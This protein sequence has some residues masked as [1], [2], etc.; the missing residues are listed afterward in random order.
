M[1]D[2]NHVFEPSRL[3]F[4]VLPGIHIGQKDASVIFSGGPRDI[5]IAGGRAVHRVFVDLQETPLTEDR[6]ADRL[7]AA[8]LSL[9]EAYYILECAKEYGLLGCAIT[10]RDG[11]VT[12]LFPVEGRAEDPAAAPEPDQQFAVSRFCYVRNRDRR[13]VIETPLCT[14]V[15]TLLDPALLDILF[16]F[17]TPTKLSQV[18]HRHPT[19][20]AQIVAFV[21]HLSRIGV[22]IQDDE[23]AAADG[24]GPGNWEFHDLLF[25]RRTRIG[26]HRYPVGA[27]TSAPAQILPA[28][29]VKQ[30]QFAAC[31]L[32]DLP[33]PDHDMRRKMA[34]RRFADV[35]R[36]R[37]SIRSYARP[38]TLGELGGFLT[39]S[40][41]ARQRPDSLRTKTTP[42]L[43]LHR[44]Y[45]TGG[46]CY[47]LE[48]YVFARECTGL[49]AG[50][51]HYDPFRHALRDIG[52][53]FGQQRIQDLQSLGFDALP[54]GG[55]Q[56]LIMISSFHQRLSMKYGSIAYALTLKHVG[57]LMQSFYLAA[58]ALDLSPCALGTGID[59][60]VDGADAATPFGELL[61]GEFL[62]GGPAAAP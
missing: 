15:I 16:S 52:A 17:S 48:I 36:R 50:A 44:P 34:D 55:G 7:C 37:G 23:D 59:G 42:H 13:I 38:L 43:G 25:H 2:E 30:R 28:H 45:P 56:L 9:V 14:D 18:L 26:G 10:S 4:L 62:L 41:R 32:I 20:T 8:G 3:A 40:A 12:A 60:S 57:A 11:R 39:L 33:E 6:V 47:D 35:I 31:D 29:D 1:A 51:Y 53:I 22:L 24:D 46:A 5:S 61:V 49:R 54:H 21:H 19:D 58:T 27:T